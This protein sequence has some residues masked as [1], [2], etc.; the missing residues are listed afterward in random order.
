MDNDKLQPILEALFA[1][2]DKPISINQ[3]FELFV[4]DIDQPNKD[5]IR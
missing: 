4:G 5:D 3:L 1:A 2:S